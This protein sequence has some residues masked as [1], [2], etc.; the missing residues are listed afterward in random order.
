VDVLRTADHEVFANATH[1]LGNRLR[2]GRTLAG[3][4]FYIEGQDLEKVNV[5]AEDMEF[6]GGSSAAVVNNAI[7]SRLEAVRNTRIFARSP[8]EAAS[9]AWR[10]RSCARLIISSYCVSPLK[11]T[12]ATSRLGQPPTVRR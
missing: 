8:K 2:L 5:M 9:L 4:D 10:K 11:M 6:G 3:R 1:H 12:F 7:R